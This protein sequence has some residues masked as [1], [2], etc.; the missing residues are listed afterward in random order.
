[1]AEGNLDHDG[2]LTAFGMDWVL[3]VK[4]ANN[5][6]AG[7]ASNGATAGA[8]VITKTG[9]GDNLAGNWLIDNTKTGIYNTFV[10]GLKPDGGFA[11]WLVDGLS[12]T[13]S[14]LSHGL[15]HANLYGK[16]GGVPDVPLPAAAWLFGSALCGLVVVSR[17]K[18]LA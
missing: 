15:S 7:T 18:K 16:V 14:A 5:G 4:D 2:S 1:M 11:Y 13:Y 6:V 8:L 17:R 9:S 3:L 10:I 12:G